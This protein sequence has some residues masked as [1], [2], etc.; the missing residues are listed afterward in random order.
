MLRDYVVK[1]EEIKNYFY[2]DR[3]NKILVVTHSTVMKAV[4]AREVKYNPSKENTM[5]SPF[6]LVGYQTGDIFPY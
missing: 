1:H 5:Q 4:T 2:D 6:D 3:R